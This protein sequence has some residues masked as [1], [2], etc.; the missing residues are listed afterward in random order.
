MQNIQK[1]WEITKNEIKSCQ[2]CEYRYACSDCR[3]LALGVF[4][5]KLAKYPRCC[6]SPEEG[7]WKNIEQVTQE[8]NYKEV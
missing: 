2:N 7:V 8:I 5:D 3:P 4:D 6:Y 1:S